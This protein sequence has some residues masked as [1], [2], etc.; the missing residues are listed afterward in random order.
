VAAEIADLIR[1]RGREGE[2]GAGA[3]DRARRRTGVYDEL[4]RLHREEGL[5]F[6][7]VVTFNLD[8]YWPM[9]PGDLQSYRRFMDEHLFD[10][11]DI[12]RANTHVPDGTIPLA[13]GRRVLRGVRA[14]DPRGG[15]DRPADPRHRA[16]GAHRVQR[17]GSGR[18]SARG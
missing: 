17:A 2:R 1:P 8:E 4:V 9:E 5:S 3:R 15:R 13:A 12:D 10:H 11:V 16:D 7:N 14:E 6:A 18:D